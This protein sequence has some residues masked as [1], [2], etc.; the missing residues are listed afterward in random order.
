MYCEIC[1]INLLFPKRH[2]PKNAPYLVRAKK[3][4]KHVGEIDP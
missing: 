3:Q 2:M 1:Q 4:Q